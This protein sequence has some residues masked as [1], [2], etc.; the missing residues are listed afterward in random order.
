MLSRK[1]RLGRPGKDREIRDLIRTGRCANLEKPIVQI[2]DDAIKA[3]RIKGMGK[4]SLL[5]Q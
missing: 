5:I 1:N 4:D 2:K 3:R